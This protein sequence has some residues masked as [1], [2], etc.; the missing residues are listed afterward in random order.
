MRTEI[1]VARISLS[2]VLST[3]INDWKGRDIVGFHVFIVSSGKTGLIFRAN[4]TEDLVGS[5]NGGIELVLVINTR[6]SSRVEVS[7]N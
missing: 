7:Q 3:G 6:V 5:S 2:R 1:G 4:G